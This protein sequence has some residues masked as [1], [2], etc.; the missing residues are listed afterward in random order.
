MSFI[1]N[2][3]PMLTRVLGNLSELEETV[4]AKMKPFD[5]WFALLFTTVGN[6]N[7]QY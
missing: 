3:V 2:T 1:N 7:I 5:R 4:S 6:I